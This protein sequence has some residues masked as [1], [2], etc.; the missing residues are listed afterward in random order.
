M[1]QLV[2]PDVFEAY[3]ARSV[4]LAERVMTNTFHCRTSDCPGWCIFEDDVNSF[5]CPVCKKRNCLTCQAIHE[6]MDCRQ[7]QRQMAIAAETDED[8]KSSRL[9]LEVAI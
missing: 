6:D 9:M 5:L 2:H 4:K 1:S 3:L 8:A 7:Y